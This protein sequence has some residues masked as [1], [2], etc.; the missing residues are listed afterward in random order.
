MGKVTLVGY[1]VV[2]EEDLE[3]V[4]AELPTHIALTRAEPGCISFE[5]TPSKHGSG[6][7]DVAEAFTNRAAFERHQERVKTSRWGELTVNVARHYVVE[8][9]AAAVEEVATSV[10][11]EA[12]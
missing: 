2:R 7:F 5:V 12:K 6:Q 11:E 3:S 4:L 10:D 8:E 9:E 1:I